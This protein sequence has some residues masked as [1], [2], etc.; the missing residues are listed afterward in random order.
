MDGMPA[1]SLCVRRAADLRFRGQSHSLAVDLPE[2]NASGL[3]QAET[4]FRME[5]E[6]RYGHAS[7]QAPVELVNLRVIVERPR[8]MAASRGKA[9][10]A[11]P[12]PAATRSLWVDEASPVEA[13]MIRRETLGAGASIA[14][15]AI[16]E[17]Y[18]STIV[19]GRG[20]RLEVIDDTGTARITVAAAGARSARASP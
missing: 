2:P 17:Q 13:P 6:Q 19:L 11:P 16:V 14:G 18:D 7:D 1:G 9:A 5:H 8:R 3:R 12:A 20:D 4:N 10:A 15:P